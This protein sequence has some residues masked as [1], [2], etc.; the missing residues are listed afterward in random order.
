MIKEKNIILENY[1]KEIQFNFHYIEGLIVLLL[2][3]FV[4]L[5]HVKT[6]RSKNLEVKLLE[7]TKENY[8]VHIVNTKIINALCFGGLTGKNIFV[9]TPVLGILNEREVIAVCLH[10]AGHI[11]SFDVLQ[12]LIAIA[13]TNFF[14]KMFLEKLYYKL[15]FDK[16]FHSTKISGKTKI[17]LLTKLPIFLA[18]IVIIAGFKVGGL[19]NKIREY[20]ADNY[21]AK[22][23]YGKDIASALKKLS[24]EISKA[25]YSAPLKIF[26]KIVEFSAS[27]P[28]TKDRIERVLKNSEFYDSIINSDEKKLKDVV[29]KEVNENQS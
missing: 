27:H 17:M 6:E 24:S 10:E 9:T 19:Y 7:V 21:A 8:K 2:S 14:L 13:T 15:L 5:L 23:G 1:L 4:F 22:F 28:K 25:K 16:I 26:M 3:F 20:E 18:F 29:T 11:K 12:R